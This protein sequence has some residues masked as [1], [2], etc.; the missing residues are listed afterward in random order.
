MKTISSALIA[1]LFSLACQAQV[2]TTASYVDV[3][4]YIGKWYAITSL[5]QFFTRNCKAQTAEYEIINEKKIS[6][7]NTCIKGKGTTTI[8]GQAVVK[9]P[10]TNAE[11]IVTF[12]NF[13]TRLFR[14]KGDYTIIKLDENYEHV[15]VGSKDRRSLWVLSRRPDMDDETLN[16][17]VEFA[18][19]E[20]FPVEKLQR[21]EF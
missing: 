15:L 19:K 12:N 9:N 2:L 7:L 18:R 11:L 4:R 8:S 16:E 14:V 10:K 1:L 20:G 17:Y 6:V 13:F 3:S 5:P 21:S